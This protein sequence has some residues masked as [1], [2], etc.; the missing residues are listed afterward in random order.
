VVDMISNR[1]PTDITLV[2]PKA[3]LIVRRDLHPAIQYLLLA[4]AEEIHAAP[5]IFQQ[6][7]QFP[8]H[9][10]EDL[11][12][13]KE[14]IRY[15]K[16][17]DRFLQRYLPFWLAVVAGRILVLLIPL[18]AI[19]YPLLR[20]TPALYGW[21]MRRRIF[22]LYGELRFIEIEFETK[23]NRVTDDM[24]ERL[25]RLEERA[26]HLRVPRAF[27]TLLYTL[28]VHIGMVRDRL[29]E[30]VPREMP[31]SCFRGTREVPNDDQQ[32]ALRCL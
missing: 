11:P 2:A 17:G 24:L 8:A 20:T 5:G 18:I 30:R 29:K 7:G 13:S 3:S 28:R 31:T 19:A 26:D 1:P 21:S 32:S 4:A 6:P 23:G 12:L 22:R 16:S 14:A 9:E 10:E 15:F 27:A 25:N